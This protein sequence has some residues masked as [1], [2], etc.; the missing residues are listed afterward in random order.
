M[1]KENLDNLD[2]HDAEETHVDEEVKAETQKMGKDEK[3][4]IDSVDKTDDGVKRAP[5]RKGDKSNGQKMEKLPASRASKIGAMYSEMNKMSAEELNTLYDAFM[6]EESDEDVSEE[7]VEESVY[8]Y[9]GELNALVESEA[10]LSEEFKEKTATI[11]EAALTSRIAEE[12]SRLEETYQENLDE[13]IEE[14]RTELVEKVNAYLNYVVEQWVE[15]NQL[16]VE[17]GLRTEIAEDFMSSLKELFVE[18]YIDVPESKVDLVDELAEKVD[19][20]ESQLNETMEVAIEQAQ[21]IEDFERKD[22]V[23]EAAEGLA[24]TEIEKLLGLVENIEFE[25]AETFAEKVETIKETY[26][27]KASKKTDLEESV[28]DNDDEIETSSSMDMYV[29]NLRKF[30]N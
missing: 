24:D 16:A 22:I 1:D 6:G 8:D 11:F 9:S 12:V 17:T 29:R 13:A 25:D 28:S 3:A 27:S 10:T 2:L 19:I 23:V 18:S 26:F 7:A 21:L 15:E 30:E 4:S 5:A 14:T 20:L